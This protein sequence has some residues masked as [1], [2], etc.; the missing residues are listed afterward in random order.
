MDSPTHIFI[1]E[2][3]VVWNKMARKFFKII[4]DSSRCV[5]EQAVVVSTT[6][7]LWD[8]RRSAK[9]VCWC[10]TAIFT[11]IIVEILKSMGQH[12]DIF[13]DKSRVVLMA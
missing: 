2:I 7:I 12:N 5:V 10:R 11:G 3:F 13:V 6:P 1:V 8:S 4:Y 9:D